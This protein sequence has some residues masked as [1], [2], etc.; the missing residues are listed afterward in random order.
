MHQLKL[1]SA[2]N[3]K[4]RHV[5]HRIRMPDQHPHVREG[6]PIPPHEECEVL[7]G[8]GMRTWADG[9]TLLLGSPSL[10]RG[11]KVKV[12]K[13]A[14]DWVDKLRHQAETPLLLAVLGLELTD[15]LFAID[16]VP[17]AFS[18]SH[19]KFIVYSSNAFAIM[20]LRS[21]YL[22]LSRAISEL[23]YLHYGLAGVLAFAGLKLIA[24]EWIEISAPVSIGIIVLCIGGAVVASLV[25]RK[26][27]GLP[28]IP[29]Q[30]Q[31]RE[32]T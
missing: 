13:K 27:Q 6:Q 5:Q 28:A 1:A 29:K 8:L 3:G 17:A 21:L 19:E 24:S 22:V 23:E 10:L 16:S 7:V 9:R 30:N 4:H 18:V 2:R 31:Q 14:Q 25:H 15:I 32:H 26:K 12:S 11:E 20:G